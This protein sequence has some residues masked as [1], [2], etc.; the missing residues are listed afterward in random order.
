MGGVESHALGDHLAFNA[1]HMPGVPGKML[2][3]FGN[4]S[5]GGLPH[6]DAAAD[7]YIRQFTGPGWPA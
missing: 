7:V 2:F 6:G 3:G 4:L 1:G 5:N